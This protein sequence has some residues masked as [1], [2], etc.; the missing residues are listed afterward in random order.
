MRPVDQDRRMRASVQR[1]EQGSLGLAEDGAADLCRNRG[2][3]GVADGGQSLRELPYV[4]GTCWTS[5]HLAISSEWIACKERP[6]QASWNMIPHPAR[7]RRC[8][9]ATATASCSPE[10]TGSASW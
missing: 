9:A 4:E 5:A 1:H 2:V 7:C 8:T 6:R 10:M 3:S